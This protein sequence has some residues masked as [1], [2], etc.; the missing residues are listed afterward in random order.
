LEFLA[1]AAGY[2]RRH[3]HRRYDAILPR[4]TIFVTRPNLNEFIDYNRITTIPKTTI[5]IIKPAVMKKLYLSSGNKSVSII[6]FVSMIGRTALNNIVEVAANNPI[7]TSFMTH[8][9]NEPDETDNGLMKN[10]ITRSSETPKSTHEYFVFSL[11][12]TM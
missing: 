10:K 5:I 4:L 6:P 11:Y 2:L 12:W 7:T 1:A 8:D 9:A 3:R